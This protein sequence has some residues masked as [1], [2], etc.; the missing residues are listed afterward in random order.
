MQV[1][2]NRPVPR[3]EITARIE[4]IRTRLAADGLDGA[5]FNYSVDVFYFTGT[6]QN[7][8]L[9]MPTEGVP[10]LLVR[11]SFSRA[12]QESALGDVRPFPASRD[13]PEIFGKKARKIGLTFDV[14]PVQHYTFYRNLLP[15]CEFV[16]ISAVNR[17]LRSVK[18]V[19]ELEQMRIG[20]KLLAEAFSHIPEFLRPGMRELDLAADFE[21]HLRMAGIGGYLRIRGFNQEITGIAVSGRN[22][23]L[24]GCFDGRVTGRGH[25]TAAPY[26]PSTDRI[27]EGQPIMVD[28]G[29]FYNGYIVDMTRIFCFGKLAPELEKA[30]R[31]SLAILAWV[32]ENLIPG[33]ICE[34]LF[35]GAAMM[36]AEA[37]LGENFMGHSGE[38]AKFVGHGVGLELDELPVLAPK[39]KAPLTAGQTIAVEPT[40]LFPEKGAV[41]IEN[42]FAV[43]ESKCEKLTDLPDNIVYM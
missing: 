35:T 31:T 12:Q 33:R 42:T 37:G 36:A 27:S 6:R 7:C 30:F 39:F 15:D 11:K 19:W 28:Y 3:E 23:A 26:G 16:D 13:L 20:G 22:A 4:K 17:D 43:T 2:M 1:M 25:W 38:L 8:V 32:R 40:F 21:H 18:S 5:L 9:W 10:V 24:A 29:G 14:L 34:D 41:G